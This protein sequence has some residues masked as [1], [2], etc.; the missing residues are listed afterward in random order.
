MPYHL[1]KTYIKNPS[2][3]IHLFIYSSS[4]LSRNHD[5]IRAAHGARIFPRWRQVFPK[6]LEITKSFAKLLQEYFFNVF[7]KIQK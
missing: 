6:F 7:A 4:H 5:A 1:L 2:L 3:F